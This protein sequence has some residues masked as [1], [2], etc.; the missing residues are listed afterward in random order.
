M[1]KLLLSILALSVAVCATAAK[2]RVEQP[3]TPDTTPR[4]IEIAT[5]NTAILLT[6]DSKGELLFRYYGKR[7]ADPSPIINKKLTRRVD[8]CTDPQAYFAQGGREQRRASLAVTHSDGDLNTELRYVSHDV[9]SENGVTTTTITT[10]D[11][12]LPFDVRLVYKAYEAE[13][14]IVTHSEITN[15]EAGEVKLRNYYS[16]NVT[17]IADHYYLTQFYGQWAREMYMS[18]TQLVKGVK[19]IYSQKHVRGVQLENP[20]F[21]VALPAVMLAAP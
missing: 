3:L 15:R 6:V 13:D 16:A 7:I 10:S 20:S 1:K 4:V 17:L 9:K 18:E 8:F 11:S 21:M 5:K 19:S 2:K 12:K 14:V